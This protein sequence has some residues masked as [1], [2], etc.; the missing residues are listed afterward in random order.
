MWV[1]DVSLACC[2][3]A[4]LLIVTSIIGYATEKRRTQERI[5]KEAFSFSMVDYILEEGNKLS[6]NAL[7]RITRTSLNKFKSLH[8]E[9][10]E[11]YQGCI[12]KDK[13]L[14]QLINEEIIHY[15]EKAESFRVI[16]ANPES[17][18][19]KI[20]AKFDELWKLERQTSEKIDKWMKDKSFV[21]G[22]EFN[23]DED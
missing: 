4:V 22:K 18:P 1:K 13:K 12:F 6:L 7:A 16:L 17:K 3:S 23:I 14:K 10:K 5:I 21:L 11:Y 2:G 15:A 9:L 19:D 20:N 8:S